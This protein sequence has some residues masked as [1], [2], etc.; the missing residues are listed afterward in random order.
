MHYLPF[1]R[2]SAGL[3]ISKIIYDLRPFYFSPASFFSLCPPFL[4]PLPPNHTSIKCAALIHFAWGLLDKHP[5]WKHLLSKEF[6]R[7][8]GQNNKAVAQKKQWLLY[9]Y[10]SPLATAARWWMTATGNGETRRKSYSV[11]GGSFKW[12]C[13]DRHAG[14]STSSCMDV[15]WELETAPPFS[16]SPSF[17]V[18]FNYNKQQQNRMIKV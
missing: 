8:Q 3:D 15:L 17:P 2:T 5:G 16:P 14:T 9:L 10:N 13:R 6:F 7:V 11:Q 12:L 18:V 4:T 1:Q